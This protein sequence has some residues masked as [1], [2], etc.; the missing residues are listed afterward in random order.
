MEKGEESFTASTGL[1]GLSYSG[2]RKV[3]DA[4][5]RH[6]IYGKVPFTVYKL[7]KSAQVPERFVNLQKGSNVTR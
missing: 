2:Q 1:E 7:L 4:L 5:G 6:A 3:V